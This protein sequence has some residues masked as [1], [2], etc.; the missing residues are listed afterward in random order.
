MD[1]N[2]KAINELRKELG[3]SIA[4]LE[5]TLKQDQEKDIW[6]INEKLN[7]VQKSDEL[8]VSRIDSLEKAGP[9]SN[10]ILT[11]YFDDKMNV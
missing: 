11:S 2:A 10:K 3:D 7:V 8:I 4:K 6:T 9:E 5:I 1:N